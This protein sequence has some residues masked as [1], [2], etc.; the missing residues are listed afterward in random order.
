MSDGAVRS[1]P[2]GAGRDRPNVL[3]ITA[4]DLMQRLRD[5]LAKNRGQTR[6]LTPSAADA[7]R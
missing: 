7:L 2:Q 6:L 1:N 3:L 5:A 4:D